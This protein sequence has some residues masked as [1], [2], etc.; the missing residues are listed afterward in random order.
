MKRRHWII[1]PLVVAAFWIA[2]THELSAQPKPEGELVVA[3]HVT[4]APAWFDPGVT[5]SGIVPFGILD[6]RLKGQ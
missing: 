4:L 6:V 5:P 1:L 2:R 3:W